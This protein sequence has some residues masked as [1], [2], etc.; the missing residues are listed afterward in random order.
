MLLPVT[1]S[2]DERTE[3]R[4]GRSRGERSEF[5]VARRARERDDVTD[6]GHPR[7]VDDRPLEPEAKSGM[8]HRAVSPEVAIPAVVFLGQAELV[9]SGIEHVESLLALGAPDDFADPR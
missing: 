2:G 8:R 1:A 5:G 7:G 9:Q 6:V 4:E 3:W